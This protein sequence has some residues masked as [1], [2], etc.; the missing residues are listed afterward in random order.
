MQT[1]GAY[2]AI[3]HVKSVV[4]DLADMRGLIEHQ[5]IP[6]ELWLAQKV[7]EWRKRYVGD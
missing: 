6:I 7:S 3:G 4:L 1:G 5:L 2:L